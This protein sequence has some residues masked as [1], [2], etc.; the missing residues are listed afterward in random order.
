MPYRKLSWVGKYQVLLLTV[1]KVAS[2]NI[3]A[4][5]VLLKAYSE[6]GKLLSW[7]ESAA[8]DNRNGTDFER[9][10]A[11]IYMDLLQLHRSTYQLTTR[12]GK[13]LLTPREQINLTV[14]RLANLLF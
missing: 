6:I 9:R 10:L 1:R 13:I 2:D 3:E 14:C 4:F 8:D 11:V 5:E 7:L 12:I